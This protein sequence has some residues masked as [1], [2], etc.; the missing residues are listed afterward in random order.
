MAKAS[1]ADVNTKTFYIT[2]NDITTDIKPAIDYVRENK[3][4]IIYYDD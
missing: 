4:A 2:D 1:P 3:T